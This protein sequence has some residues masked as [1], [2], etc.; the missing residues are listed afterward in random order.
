MSNLEQKALESANKAF[1]LVED[2][3]WDMDEEFH[4]YH[5]IAFK[6]GYE[7]CQIEFTKE[8]VI[9]ILKARNEKAFS[10]YHKYEYNRMLEAIATIEKLV[11]PDCFFYNVR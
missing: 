9:E 3:T 5:Q 11:P 4:N 1:G 6:E 10:K 7:L 8:K 2:M